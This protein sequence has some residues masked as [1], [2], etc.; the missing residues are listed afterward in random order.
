MNKIMQI[1]KELSGI[2]PKFDGDE[3]LLNLFI[4][5]CE[6]VIKLSRETGNLEQDIYIF[7]VITS[8]L[9]GKAATLISERPDIETW[10]ELKAAFEQHFGDPRSE[11]CIAIELETLKIKNGES[12]L[13][14]CNRIQHIKS[15]L[16][17]KV[18]R[19]S[20]A[21]LRNSKITI[22]DHMSMNVFL[23][24][25]PED[26]LR[27]VRLK[28]CTSLENALSIVLEEVNFLYQYQTRN[29]MFR[30]HNNTQ[31]KPQITQNPFIDKNVMKP[32]FSK[33][34]QQN[35]F[36]FGIPQQGN[37]QTKP[38]YQAQ[39]R[40]SQPNFKFGITPGT[41]NT[42][43]IYQTQPKF[44]PSKQFKVPQQQF[45]YRPPSHLIRPQFQPK[46]QSTDVSMRTA[47]P[48]K[49][50]ALHMNQL[51]NNEENDIQY[52]ENEY[53][54]DE[55]NEYYPDENINS[56]SEHNESLLNE[57]ENFPIKALNKNPK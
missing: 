41:Y 45:G 46:L 16:F 2:I 17:A 44:T 21:N 13:D 43:P 53:Y 35:N 51:Y 57:D 47:P 6:Y 50:Q 25:L 9:A 38:I 55:N 22:Y 12:Y 23:Y 49:P 14:F 24:N 29:K 32:F 27:I 31:Q 10:N 18:N 52:D 26:L 40:Q 56:L 48:V 39:Y 8:K 4:R 37:L 7:Q 19:I 30:S 11:E 1:P 42:K 3:S 15:T 36:K 20:D 33:D 54:V 34:T 28:G 5:K